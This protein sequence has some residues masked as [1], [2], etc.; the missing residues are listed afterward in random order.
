MR[1]AESVTVAR[2]SFSGPHIRHPLQLYPVPTVPM[3]PS[4]G[5]PTRMHAHQRALGPLGQDDASGDVCDRELVVIRCSPICDRSTVD[6]HPG[7]GF[8]PASWSDPLCPHQ[9]PHHQ[10]LDASPREHRCLCIACAPR[11]AERER[12]AARRESITGQQPR[13]DTGQQPRLDPAFVFT[14]YL[15]WEEGRRHRRRHR[16]RRRRQLRRRPLA[17][18]RRRV[19]GSPCAWPAQRSF[20]CQ[21]LPAS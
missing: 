14:S 3:P 5:R 21:P 17:H 7:T 19:P 6:L 4:Q 2:L 15:C 11:A 12:Q 8:S 16:R 1:T 20:P 18:G 9:T 13:L 10:E